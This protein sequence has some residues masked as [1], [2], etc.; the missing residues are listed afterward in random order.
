M[1]SRSGWQVPPEQ[2]ASD[3][4]MAS[5][6][7]S[8]AAT[9]A[10]TLLPA[11]SWVWKWMRVPSGSIWRAC[12]TVSYTVAGTEVP[13]ASLKHTESKGIS[14]SRICRRTPM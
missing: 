8:R 14:A 1:T 4:S 2:G 7:A 5:A 11:V 3:R 9:L 12:L 13:E 6:L 10:V